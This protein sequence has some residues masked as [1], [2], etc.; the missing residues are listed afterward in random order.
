VVR[1]VMAVSQRMR[2]S[3]ASNTFESA[4]FRRR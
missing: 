3:G 2:L 4:Q 1:I